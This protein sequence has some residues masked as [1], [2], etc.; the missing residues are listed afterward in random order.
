M[1]DSED[2]FAF[3]GSGF[4]SLGSESEESD[5]ESEGESD[6][7]PG[8][9]SASNLDKPPK[10]SEKGA[11]KSDETAESAD[12]T[13]EDVA[14][15][16][17]AA[18][19]PAA[20]SSGMGEISPSNLSYSNPC[21]YGD[22]S[23]CYYN[24]AKTTNLPYSA[25]LIYVSFF[26]GQYYSTF[27]SLK[28]PP[29]EIETAEDIVFPVWL[30]DRILPFTTRG[31]TENQTQN[32]YFDAVSELFK[33]FVSTV[34]DNPQKYSAIAVDAS[35]KLFQTSFSKFFT[36]SIREFYFNANAV[37]TRSDIDALNAEKEKLESERKIITGRTKLAVEEL[38]KQKKVANLGSSTSFF[39][40]QIKNARGAAERRKN[41]I[42]A[43]LV[44]LRQRISNLKT[45]IKPGM[46]PDEASLKENLRN[47][48]KNAW[49]PALKELLSIAESARLLFDSLYDEDTRR[50]FLESPW[51]NKNSLRIRQALEG[52][53]GYMQFLA[54]SVDFEAN[55]RGDTLVAWANTRDAVLSR[56]QTD[57]GGQVADFQRT[58]FNR[59]AGIIGNAKMPYE[60]VNNYIESSEAIKKFKL[61]PDQIDLEKILDFSSVVQVSFPGTP[62]FRRSVGLLDK[63]V[64][65]IWV[66]LLRSYPKPFQPKTWGNTVSSDL[67]Q[68]LGSFPAV[69]M[70][71]TNQNGEP[72][73]VPWADD[74]YQKSLTLL[75]FRQNAFV[76]MGSVASQLE[77]ASLEDS[78]A[79]K[80]D[81]S[82]SEVQPP[83]P[84]KATIFSGDH[85]RKLHMRLEEQEDGQNRYVAPAEIALAS[86]LTLKMRLGDKKSVVTFAQDDFCGC[87]SK[88]KRQNASTDGYV[89]AAQ[90][91]DRGSVL[92]E[93]NPDTN[94]VRRVAVA[95]KP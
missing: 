61:V 64:S 32:A 11:E 58:I 12:Q 14:D 53:Y 25:N 71:Q 30:Y 81:L 75:S 93:A 62:F 50:G 59:V 68:L 56:I 91:F 17:G 49:Y 87:K 42:D 85:A 10:K 22:P 67:D 31:I 5:V 15:D 4:G 80:L 78:T 19:Q 35:P 52:L 65:Y 21:D 94:T 60:M 72:T 37:A 73:I 6:S 89:W 34:K 69:D 86:T 24:N 28:I 79:E 39:D 18:E 55:G 26:I 54:Y 8:S 84:L 76:S 66:F 47:R 33:G 45:G 16:S 70:F 43:Q 95:Y 44:V 36:L 27:G 38:K 57:L 88:K 2:D 48:L 83:K 13:E 9:E 29:R 77:S 46:V 74:F 63:C 20:I 40:D 92:V 1:S 41:E 23:L 7:L 82:S 90:D 3:L 51:R